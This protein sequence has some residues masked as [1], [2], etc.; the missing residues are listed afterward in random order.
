MT[1]LN[2]SN[3]TIHTARHDPTTQKKNASSWPEWDGSKELYPTFIIQLAAKIDTDWDLLGG[4]KAVCMDMMNTIPKTL[5]TRVS[6]WLS[7]GGPNRD[8]N[9]QLFII[10]FNDNFEDKTSVRTANEKLTRMRQG[11]HQTFASYLNDFEHMLAQSGGVNRDGYVK[12]NSLHLGLNERL[13]NLLMLVSLSDT[14][15]TMFVKE[16]RN[17]AGKLESREDFI[18][19]HGV[20]WTKT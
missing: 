13:T 18:P 19:R 8:W 12:I 9:Y 20:K 1:I 15:Y 4:N 11:Q 16:V 14:N 17:I 3:D 5:R 6:Q 10:H 7:T 2:V